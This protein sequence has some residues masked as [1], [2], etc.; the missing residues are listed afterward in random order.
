LGTAYVLEGAT[1]GGQIITRHLQQE[2]GIQPECG[3]AF[4]HSYGA[5]VA[6]MWREFVE[7]LNTYPA[8]E[9]E[10]VALVASACETFSS[11]EA[12]LGDI[13]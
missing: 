2:L 13:D 6:P 12:W 8:T 7:V 10:Q 11:L 1:L 4:F 9:D 5:S 3:G